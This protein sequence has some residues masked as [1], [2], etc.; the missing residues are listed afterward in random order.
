MQDR[1]K[2]RSMEGTQGRGGSR[3]C[4]EATRTAGAARERGGRREHGHERTEHEEAKGQQ[5]GACEGRKGRMKK[6]GRG[7]A[8]ACEERTER[9]ERE[10]GA[11][12][13]EGMSVR[14]KSE[15]RAREKRTQHKKEA[16]D[17][18]GTQGQSRSTEGSGREVRRERT[19]KR[20][21]KGRRRQQQPRRNTET[22]RSRSSPQRRS[23]PLE[24]QE[25]KRFRDQ[26]R[27]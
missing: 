21:Q 24:T 23:S 16:C 1:M 2:D 15:W 13:H 9:Y 18:Q 12:A 17:P 4:G 6:R 27:L 11:R 25:R 8:R 22:K 14:R 20:R 5:Q 10:R 19:K 7:P 3:R 26:L